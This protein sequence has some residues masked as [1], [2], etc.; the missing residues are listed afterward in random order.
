MFITTLINNCINNN[1]NNA[2]ENNN[3]SYCNYNNNNCNNNYKNN[4]YSNKLNIT[5]L[6]KTK[7]FSTI[8]FAH[9]MW[10]FCE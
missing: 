10:E 8:Y 1:K 6:K 9:N 5:F 2:Y 4:N 7:Q 3:Y